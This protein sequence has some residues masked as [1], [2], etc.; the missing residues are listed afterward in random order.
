MFITINKTVLFW[1]FFLNLCNFLPLKHWATSGVFLMCLL[2]C[3]TQRV[4]FLG[5][6]Y[7]Y[8]ILIDL[9]FSVW[10]W[11]DQ[12]G[13][14]LVRRAYPHSVLAP[15]FLL[16]R[17]Q[18]PPSSLPFYSNQFPALFSRLFS[19]YIPNTHLKKIF[20]SWLDCIES[21]GSKPL[22]SLPN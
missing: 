6:S 7:L 4:L 19:F 13:K 10:K 22:I 12:M 15:F 5:N 17:T 3:Q 11:P 18:F 16:C 20:P 8:R 9:N 21:Q 1:V 14:R 2:R